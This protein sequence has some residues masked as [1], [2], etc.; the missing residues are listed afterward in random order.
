MGL[1]RSYAHLIQV[2]VDTCSSESHSGTDVPATFAGIHDARRSSGSTEIELIPAA[3]QTRLDV[4]LLAASSRGHDGVVQD[5][6]VRGARPTASRFRRYNQE[7]TALHLASMQGHMKTVRLLIEGGALSSLDTHVLCRVLESGDVEL[8]EALPNLVDLRTSLMWA[9]D[10]GEDRLVKLL[11][12]NGVSTEDVDDFGR[13]VLHLAV[14]S[15]SNTTIRMLLDRGVPLDTL[16]PSGTALTMAARLGRPDVVQTLLNYNPDLSN[17]KW[18]EPLFA[19]ASGKYLSVVEDILLQVVQINESGPLGTAL[20]GA[21]QRNLVKLVEIL[22]QHK[23]AVDE[24]KVGMGTPLQIATGKRH[25]GIMRLL[26]DG[27]ANVNE[28]GGSQCFPL[29]IAFSIVS[30]ERSRFRRLPTSPDDVLLE[31]GD[32]SC[33]AASDILSRALTPL[34]IAVLMGSEETVELLLKSGADATKGQWYTPPRLAARMGYVGIAQKLLGSDGNLVTLGPHGIHLPLAAVIEHRSII[35][36]LVEPP[37]A[38]GD[39][40]VE[41]SPLQLASIAGHQRIVQL[42]LYYGPRCTR[43][44]LQSNEIDVAAR[45]QLRSALSIAMYARQTG[46]DNSNVVGLI[47][48]SGFLKKNHMIHALL[49]AV[50]ENYKEHVQQFLVHEFDVNKVYFR[51]RHQSTDGTPPTRDYTLLRLAI[52]HSCAAVVYL[53]L[54][55]GAEMNDKRHGLCP[56]TSAAAVKQDRI[57]R[58]LVRRGADIELAI[59]CAWDF[60]DAKKI[61]RR[62]RRLQTSA[63]DRFSEWEEDSSLHLLDK[64]CPQFSQERITPTPHREPLLVVKSPNN[65]PAQPSAEVSSSRPRSK[66][67]STVARLRSR[68]SRV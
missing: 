68:L 14:E 12:N 59:R 35:E 10:Q 61:A 27:G 56:L 33:W 44:A 26:I 13:T 41:H 52:Y 40:E 16:G 38:A 23:A 67:S 43:R 48:K 39:T 42:L 3:L 49:Y 31:A 19:V 34:Q 47:L 62:L 45:R 36:E 17:C 53:L 57:M 37:T 2:E 8:L 60:A 63:S 22:L 58:L 4:S 18:H 64:D 25:L 24:H 30:F 9:V 65:A 1:R 11:L 15:C 51:L 5:L 7:F 29:W 6:L 46:Y 20:Y 28:D 55:G 66:T 21:A 32:G 54:D 50:Q